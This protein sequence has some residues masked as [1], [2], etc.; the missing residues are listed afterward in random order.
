[1]EKKTALAL[2]LPHMETDL[3]SACFI[4]LNWKNST[5]SRCC[6]HLS[7]LFKK[8]SYYIALNYFDLSSCITMTCNKLSMV[9]K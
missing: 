4:A 7:W 2:L 6:L 8:Y 3:K 9:S 5:E 1:M